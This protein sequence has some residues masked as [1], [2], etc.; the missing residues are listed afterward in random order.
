[1]S[2][3]RRNARTTARPARFVTLLLLASL[4][5]GH[6]ALAAKPELTVAI[7]SDIPPYVM[8]KGTTGIEVDIVQRVL[9]GYTV[10]FIQM[11]YKELQTAVPQNGVDVAVSVKQFGDDGV[12]SSEDFVTF[13]NFATTKKAAGLKI[14]S[15]ADLA[16]H[17]VLAWQDASL[18]LGPEFKR[19]FS[20]ESPQRKNYVEVDDQREQV[21]MFWQAKADIIV[22][23]RSIFSYFSAE[24]GHSTSEVAFHSLFP[25]VTNFKVGFKDAAVRDAF[26]RGLT[27]LCQ[28]GD[29]AK[30]LKRYHVEL[31]HTVCDH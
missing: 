24:T 10:H 25:S 30:L 19:F 17:K 14:D 6:H 31:P 20:P 8:K 11:P 18:E 16:N 4:L 15:V 13:E 7:P 29:Y 12:F 9:A 21:R 5:A 1:M 23:D 27:R 26:N 28:S 3:D 2:R 22:I